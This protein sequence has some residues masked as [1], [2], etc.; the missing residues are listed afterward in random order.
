MKESPICLPTS[1]KNDDFNGKLGI[2]WQGPNSVILWQCKIENMLQNLDVHKILYTAVQIF[3]CTN[4]KI[5]RHDQET[6]TYHIEV[7]DYSNTWIYLTVNV[8]SRN[9]QNV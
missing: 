9:H 6:M 8:I 1:E 7:N 3:V 2:E 5:K 4:I